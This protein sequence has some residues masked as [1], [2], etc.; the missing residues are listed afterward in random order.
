MGG[1]KGRPWKRKAAVIVAHPDDEVLWAGGTILSRP[2]WQWEIYALCR[3]RDPDRAPR[4]LRTLRKLEA[5]GAIGD[6]DDG[7]DQSP[8]DPSV[9]RTAIASLLPC[10]RFNLVLT[11]GPREEYSRHR[12]HEETCRAVVQ[13]WSGGVIETEELWMFAYEDGEDAQFPVALRTA[14]RY[15]PLPTQV[16]ESK[17]CLIT[18]YYGFAPGSWEA[19][20]APR[21]EAFWCF[22]TPQAAQARLESHGESR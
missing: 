11:H 10:R 6:L 4:F 15:E 17:Y 8:L 3:A 20:A 13:L 18:E 12:R 22:D 5:D 21:A 14:D 16:W 19:Q 1:P 2:D 7:P 9:V